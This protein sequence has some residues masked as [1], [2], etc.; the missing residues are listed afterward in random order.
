MAPQCKVLKHRDKNEI[1]EWMLNGVPLRQ[2]EKK[3]KERYR[4]R[5]TWHLRISYSSLQGFKSKYIDIDEDLAKELRKAS[6][7]LVTPRKRKERDTEALAEAENKKALM[8]VPSYKKA[9]QDLAEK[10]MDTRNEMVKVWTIVEDRLEVLFDKASELGR[11][12]KD[13]EKSIQG[14]L[15]QFMSV[16]DQYKKYEEGYREQVDVNVNVNVVGEQ[17]S[18]LRDAV[19][20]T[21]SE[22]DPIL[23][24]SFMDK[25]NEKMKELVYNESSTSKSH[26]ALL[27]YTLGQQFSGDTH[28]V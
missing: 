8:K 24:V 13:M 9:I 27:D 4:N 12:D 1:I 7:P 2:I 25:L 5:N 18:I 3:L 23:M 20:E 19:R 21:L 15:G 16:I 28:D 22:V 14:Y 10:K 26:A 6:A 17:I 11:F